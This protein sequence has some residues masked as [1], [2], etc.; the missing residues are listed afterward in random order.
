MLWFCQ[1]VGLEITLRKKNCEGMGVSH[2]R[3]N[4]ESDRARGGNSWLLKNPCKC[5]QNSAVAVTSAQ[6]GSSSV[7]LFYVFPL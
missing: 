6:S 5:V 2:K 7:C 1:V 4:D 3:Q